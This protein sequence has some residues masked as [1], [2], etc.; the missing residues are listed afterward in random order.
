MKRLILLTGLFFSLTTMQAQKDMP[1]ENFQA[2][3]PKY[4]KDNNG[5]DHSIPKE[6]SWEQWVEG[7]VKRGDLGTP[8]QSIWTVYSDR[9]DNPLYKT[10][11][12][13]QPTGQ[14]LS[15]GTRLYVAK[16]ENG[17]ALVFE[18]KKTQSWGKIKGVQSWG[19]IPIENLLLWQEC[20]KSKSQ[21]YKKGLI[22]YDPLKDMS[23][24]GKVPD[25]HFLY[26][27]SEHARVSDNPA[28][29]LNILFIM[30]TVTVRENNKD[31]KYYL[32]ATETHCKN[33]S[34]LMGWLP[35]EN[36]TEWDQRLALEPAYLSG[37]V[38]SYK[39]MG[40]KPVAYMTLDKALLYYNNDIMSNG[41]LFQY[42]DFGKGQRMPAIQ[43]RMPILVGETGND[44]IN[45]VAV[46]LSTSKEVSLQ[47]RAD[48]QSNINR[49]TKLQENIN[50][51]FVIDATNSMKNFLKA[52]ADALAKINEHEFFKNPETRS[53]IKVGIVL[54][55]DAR[56]EPKS[57]RLTHDLDQVVNYLKTTKTSTDGPDD[58]VALVQGIELA[59]DCNK[60]GYEPDHSNFMILI[61][62]ASS[63]RNDWQIESVAEKLSKN[64]INFLS[65]QVSNTG[66]PAYQDFSEQ[67]GQIQRELRKKYS[68][69]T[70]GAYTFSRTR[71]GIEMIRK[72]GESEIPYYCMQRYSED[73]ER[74]SPD[75]VTSGMVKYV[76]DFYNKISSRLNKYHLMSE[77]GLR[78]NNS[79]D[80]D[81][82]REELRA[83]GW[84]NTKVEQAIKY[85]KTG[86]VAKFEAYAPV[87]T[88]SRYN[89]DYE[90]I[91]EYV[92]FFSQNELTDIIRYLDKVND[93]KSS[94]NEGLALQTALITL[95]KAMMGE[96]SESQIGKIDI[97][98]MMGK[99]YGMPGNINTKGFKLDELTEMPAEKVHDFMTAFRR[100]L[101]D[102]IGMVDND[103][104]DAGRFEKNGMIYYW[105]PLRR[106]P[107]FQLE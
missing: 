4:I 103:E 75:E 66:A 25:P 60:M 1:I 82:V 23:D 80:E 28:N 94:N 71:G 92:L 98:E 8:E 22:V 76:E 43:M 48:V 70:G 34:T 101:N 11:S 24:G 107:G 105:I 99:I 90:Y 9:N 106:I 93:K 29:S 31:K 72:N 52:I 102:L 45:K 95:G 13:A 58:R 40:L 87:A 53:H 17:F 84:P 83:A 41:A 67:V 104:V 36:V 64:N 32:L 50:I 86:G 68:T 2:W 46:T 20:P 97:N 15:L 96:L 26:G 16:I 7:K 35:E 62:D 18:T 85:M 33:T 74:R 21:I 88:A 54:Y 39:N 12:K 14:K 19:W 57:L 81:L 100:A 79:A 47:N 63:P 69:K 91:Y 5:A 78:I 61:G 6:A 38:R 56:Q 51:I 44:F 55:R 73:R 42:D 77:G 37:Q 49:L 30:K 3:L 10:A 65:Y 27:P 89:Q 59:M